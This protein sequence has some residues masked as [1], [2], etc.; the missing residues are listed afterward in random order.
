MIIAA[1]Q[2]RSAALRL[3]SFLARLAA[4]A[5]GLA[6]AGLAS[7]A[8]PPAFV[9]VLE[10]DFPD[11]FVLL[12][13][14]TFYAYA[15]NTDRG[16]RNVQLASSTNLADWAMARDSDGKPRDAMP[17]LPPWAKRGWTWAPEVLKTGSAYLLYFTAK[18][19]KTGLQC[20]G[21]AASAD[22]QGPFTSNAAEP[23]VCQR[24]LGGTIDASP[25]RDADGKL[26]LYFKNDGNAVRK[27]V[28]IWGQPLAPDGLSVTGE[29]VALLKAEKGWEGGLIEAPT[30]VHAE[31]GYDLFYSAND[32]AWQD[33]AALSPYAFG[34]APCD[35]PLG[36]CRHGKEPVL[37]S[38][39]AEGTCLSGPGHQAIF[40]VGARWFVAFHAWSATPSCHKLDWKRYLYVA[41][42]LW[43]DDVPAVG[44]SLRPRGTP[45]Q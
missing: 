2:P 9:P 29:P 43:K 24:D 36:P 18:E 37:H 19:K 20:V 6:A 10:T 14:G 27:P 11:P 22:P 21:V 40:R 33:N 41:P 1:Q 3:P 28:Q 13:G 8:E 25:L 15:T 42:L 26:Y 39:N 17:E 31:K 38:F 34:Y 45:S 12:A 44:I 5:L 30:M 4:L 23:L 32:Y 7:A 35:G 16:E